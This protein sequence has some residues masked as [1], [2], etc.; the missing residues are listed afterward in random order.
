MIHRGRRGHEGCQ[1]REGPRA[2][3]A[4]NW[5]ENDEALSAAESMSDDMMSWTESTNTRAGPRNL[6]VTAETYWNGTIQ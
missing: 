1:G 5:H 2:T 3:R 4:A 6:I